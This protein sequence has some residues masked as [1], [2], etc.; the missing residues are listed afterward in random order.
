MEEIWDILDEN[1]N[2]TGET[3]KKEYNI[4]PGIYHQGADVWIINSDNKI[5]IQKRS[6]NKKLDPGVWAMTGGSVIKGETSK[7]TIKRETKEELNIDLETENMKLIKKYKIRNVWLDV[8]IIRK[9]IDLEDIVMQEDEVVEVKWASYEEIDEIYKNKQ[10]I[11]NRWE[12]V[13]N[14]MKSIQYIGNN[15][16]VKIDR[17]L[18]SAH[19]KYSESIYPINYGFI[20][21]TI[22]G[23][24]EEL[25]CYILGENIPLKTYQGKCISVIHRLEE[26]DD[27]L[28]VVPEGKDYSIQEI[29]ELTNF[30]E[31]YYKS[32]I[33]M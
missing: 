13:R 11:E 33:I 19:P 17:P 10:F 9:D 29:K 14:I 16:N 25:D 1:G 24:G 31:K 30:Q 15:V 3:M 22:S 7:E 18:G 5:L 26:D 32:T 2:P 28:I 4:K 20:P 23:D 21:N 27:K 6:P 12:Y 8:Y